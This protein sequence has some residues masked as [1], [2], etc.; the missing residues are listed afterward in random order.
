MLHWLKQKD[1]KQ[2]IATT[3]YVGHMRVNMVQDAIP[4]SG[5]WD[6]CWRTNCYPSVHAKTFNGLTESKAFLVWWRGNGAIPE[7]AEIFL[8]CQTLIL[9]NLFLSLCLSLSI[10]KVVI[11]VLTVSVKCLSMKDYRGKPWKTI[12]YSCGKW[13]ERFSS[14]H[15]QFFSPV[16]PSHQTHIKEQSLGLQLYC[17]LRTVY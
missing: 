14:S 12:S 16:S 17:R 6:E 15:P 7:M 9:V 5:L 11:I 4:D 1:Q 8:Y 10:Y 3:K 2:N 13:D